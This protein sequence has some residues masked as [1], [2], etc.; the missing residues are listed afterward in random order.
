MVHQ[1]DVRWLS[2][3][4]GGRV[5]KFNNYLTNRP[6]ERQMIFKFQYNIEEIYNF[7]EMKKNIK[8]Y[9]YSKNDINLLSAFFISLSL[10]IYVVF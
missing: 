5:F 9:A 4:I 1:I 10:N 3:A 6:K 8:F 7:K 2:V